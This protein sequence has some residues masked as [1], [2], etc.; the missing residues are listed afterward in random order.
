MTRFVRW[1]RSAAL[2]VAALFPLLAAAQQKTPSVRAGYSQARELTLLGTISDIVENSPTGPMG[3]H[4]LLQT[5]AGPIDVHIGSSKF[6]AQNDLALRVSDNIRV[7]G[8]SFSIGS[9]TVFF[10]RI[11]Q[12]GSK[13]IAV[14]SAKGAPLWP[15]GKRVQAAAMSAPKGAL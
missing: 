12:S 13:A 2:L 10:A 9:N 3:T 1:T 6:L 15:A 11:V 8:E 7:I 4:L 14:R 5:S